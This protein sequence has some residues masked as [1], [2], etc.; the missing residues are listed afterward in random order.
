MLDGECVEGSVCV[1]GRGGGLDSAEAVRDKENAVD[2]S[3][4]C[5]A[6]DLKVAEEGVCAEKVKGLVENIVVIG[7]RVGGPAE[8]GAQGQH[9]KVSHDAVV[10]AADKEGGVVSLEL[11]IGGALGRCAG[12][13]YGHCWGWGDDDGLGWSVE[14]RLATHVTKE[15]HG[16]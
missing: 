3:A 4:V 14:F 1:S 6:L 10:G 9:G 2:K 13:T 15:Q 5:G 11:L 7:A 12:F 16:G 8:A